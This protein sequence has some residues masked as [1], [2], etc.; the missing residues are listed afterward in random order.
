MIFSRTTQTLFGIIL[1]CCQHLVAIELLAIMIVALRTFEL[2]DTSKLMKR[3]SELH[4]AGSMLRIEEPQH[5]SALVPLETA[6]QPR[7]I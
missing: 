1:V 4:L 2:P 3:F 7:L 5:F 6:G